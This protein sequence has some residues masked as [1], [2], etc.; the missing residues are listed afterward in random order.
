MSTALKELTTW[1]YQHKGE[2]LLEK[3]YSMLTVRCDESTCPDNAGSL[4]WKGR[5]SIAGNSPAKSK[6]SEVAGTGAAEEAGSKL[7][8]LDW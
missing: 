8:T 3:N 2:E 7:S 6:H 5:S 1:Q 4:E